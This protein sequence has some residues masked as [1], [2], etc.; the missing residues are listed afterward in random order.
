MSSLFDLTKLRNKLIISGVCVLV[1]FAIYTML[2]KTHFS[3]YNNVFDLFY[4][5][6]LNQLGFH[7][8]KDVYPTTTLT[9]S[10]TMVQLILAYAIYLL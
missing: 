10:I 9:K 6:V 2:P 1:F 5:T 4:S 8:P 3:N 7:F